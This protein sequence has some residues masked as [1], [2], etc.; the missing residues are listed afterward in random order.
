TERMVQAVAKIG[1]KATVKAGTPSVN[2]SQ[3]R[4]STSIEAPVSAERVSFFEVP[5]ECGAAEALGCGSASK[6]VLKELERNSKVK[7]ARTR[8]R[9]GTIAASMSRDKGERC[10]TDPFEGLTKVA[11]KQIDQRQLAELRKAAEQ[12]AGAL[13][14]ESR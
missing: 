11:R 4:A 2:S 5:L 9:T 8:T 13:P 6:P 12:G 1:Y 3:P 10:A 14:G 7:E